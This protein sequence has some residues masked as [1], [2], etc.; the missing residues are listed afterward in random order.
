M[1]LTFWKLFRIL[2]LIPLGLGILAIE[3]LLDAWSTTTS[4]FGLL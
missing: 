3:A 2:V 4:T 1:L